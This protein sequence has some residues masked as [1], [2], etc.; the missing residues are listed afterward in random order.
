M[1][2]LTSPVYLTLLLISAYA[3]CYAEGGRSS[4]AAE[5]KPDSARLHARS[6]KKTSTQ[7]APR[8]HPINNHLEC[9]VSQRE[10]R[11]VVE[12]LT[13]SDSM[14]TKIKRDVSCYVSI[15]TVGAGLSRHEYTLIDVRDEQSFGRYWIPGSMNIPAYAIRS[16]TFFKPASLLLL[17]EG[18]SSP[19]LEAV[20][21]EL[22]N[23]GFGRVAIL[24]GGL[25]AWV[26]QYGNLAGDVLAQK[27]LNLM[28]PKEFDVER[29]TT[30]WLV[31]DATGMPIS[32]VR[33]GALKVLPLGDPANSGK[34]L[35]AMRS[36]ANKGGKN[37]V[38]HQEKLLVV[39]RKGDDY[40]VVDALMRQSGV[41]SFY[42]LAGGAD[43]Y[44]KYLSDTLAVAEHPK[45]KQLPYCNG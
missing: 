14:A 15:N 22:K 9:G 20:C 40:D 19:E 24:Q 8:L 34:F 10:G 2:R 23:A 12:M 3:T 17:D 11:G 4:S 13:Q 43:G 31:L 44:E 32:P 35:S 28:T 36:L 18:R 25:N 39:T 6:G 21:A 42:Y 33:S 5:I 41:R 30:N 37:T 45:I 1:G 16:K 7:L 29:Q 38:K 27:Q 26:Q